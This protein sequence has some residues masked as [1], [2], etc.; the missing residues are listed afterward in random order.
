VIVVGLFV[1]KV[2]I[3]VGKAMVEELDG[4]VDGLTIHQIF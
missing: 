1:T 4:N 3:I 2:I